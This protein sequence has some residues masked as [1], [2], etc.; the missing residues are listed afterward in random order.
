MVRTKDESNPVNLEMVLKII[1]TKC[2]IPREARTSPS[3]LYII[4]L[5]IF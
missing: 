1:L 2:Q 3:I 5:Y 4:L